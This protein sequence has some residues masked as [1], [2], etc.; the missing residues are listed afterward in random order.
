MIDVHDIQNALAETDGWLFFDHH[1]RDPIAYRVL[2]LDAD[3]TVTR[4]WFY[5][6]PAEGEP[7]KIVHRIEAWA[8]RDLPGV[9]R[10]YATW[11]ELHAHL[12]DVLAGAKRVAMQYSPNCALPLISNVDAGTV[13]LIRG[14]GVEVVSSAALVQHF[15]ARWSPEQYEMHLEAG[16]RVDRIRAEAFALIGERIRANEPAHEFEVAEFIRQRF[17]D[18]GL[19]TDH[20]PIV[21]V[22]ANSG[23]PHY[24]PTAERTLPINRDDFVLIDLWA[25]LDRAA[26][27][28]YDVTW[29]G[30]CGDAI[31]ERIQDVFDM[32]TEARDR[33]LTYVRKARASNKAVAGWEVDKIARDYIAE[34]GHGDHFVHRLGHS[35]GEDVHGN[36]ANLDNLEAHDERPIVPR[37]CF[38]I[39]PGIY[40]P[41]FGVRSEIN[42]YVSEQSAEPTGEVQTEIV[43]IL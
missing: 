3:A 24:E 17:R 29:T 13:D 39:E 35:I 19:V 2:G 22:N 8:L 11:Q 42:C 41:D 1:H 15:E 14:L 26:G 9:D 36:G 23:D 5:W 32:V 34:Q 20:G 16:R 28:Y 21:A 37:T 4:R 12:S 7:V 43:R 38:S 31:P 40:L 10:V 25:K 18:D 6:V 27:V 33:A 30:F